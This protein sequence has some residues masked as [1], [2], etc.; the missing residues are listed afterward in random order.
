[1]A[2]DEAGWQFAYRIRLTSR[3]G[4][5]WCVLARRSASLKD[6]HSIARVSFLA[7]PVANPAA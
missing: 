4:Q 6:L 5:R 3:S 7:G 2:R 1:M